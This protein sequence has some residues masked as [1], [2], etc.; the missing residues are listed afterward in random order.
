MEIGNEDLFEAIE[1]KCNLDCDSN[2]DLGQDKDLV[3]ALEKCHEVDS[4]KVKK[5]D[6]IQN[7]PKEIQDTPDF[8]KGKEQCFVCDNCEKIF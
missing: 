6:H 8:Q 1:F 5:E 2:Q 7:N 4:K 3:H